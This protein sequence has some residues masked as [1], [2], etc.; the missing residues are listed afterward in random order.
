MK[1][2]VFVLLIV[3]LRTAADDAV[4]AH[5]HHVHLNA[6]NPQASIDFYTKIFGAVP[7]KYTDTADAVFTERSFILFNKVDQP[8]PSELKAGLWHI[9]WGAVDMPGRYAWLVEQGVKIHTPIYALNNIHVTY[10]QGPDNEL[11]EVNTMPHH[12]YAH[13]H[14]MAVDVNETVQWYKKELGVEVRRDFV[15]KPE[16][17]SKVRAWS[18][19]FNCDNVSFVVYGQPNYEPKPPWWPDAPLTGF[20][21]TDGRVIDHIAFSFRDIEPVLKRIQADGVEIV[22]PIAHRDDVNHESFFVRGPDKVL[23]EIVE[24]KP[25]PESSWE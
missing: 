8:S 2:L 25:I 5:F 13:V 22:S 9:G 23:I 6:V 3:A 1:K 10:V 14:L 12:R 18:S 24:A 15:P 19:G 17:M 4:P 7:V 16:D 11:I 21:P 20:E